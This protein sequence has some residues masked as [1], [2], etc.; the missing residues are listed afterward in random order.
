MTP[1]LK[2]WNWLKQYIQQELIPF[3]ANLKV[4]I[5]L[6]ILIA[7][8][9]STGTVIEQ[10]Q[11]LPFYQANYPESPALFGFITWKFI[12]GFGF[13]HVYHTWWFLGLLVWFGASLAA[14]TFSRQFPALKAARSWK[15][16]TQPRQFQK[17]AWSVEL[18]R[19]S[20]GSLRGYLNQRGYRIFEQD[21]GLYARKGIVGRIGPIVVH[22]SMLIILAGAMWGT[23][24]GFMAQEMVPSGQTFHIE[25]VVDAGPWSKGK[26]PQDWGVKVNRFWIEYTPQGQID[27]F[28][29]DLSVV[30]NDGDELDRQTI[31][32]NQPLRHDG[33]TFYQADWGIAAV[34]V[35]VNN[36]P[37]FEL[38][39]ASLQGT[40]GSKLWGTWV[41]TKPDMSEGITLITKDLQGT[42]VLYGMD[43]SPLG[44]VRT[45]MGV[46]VN[47]VTL[48]VLDL[49]GS[50]GL[51]IKLDP[52]IPIV[53]T[54]FALLMISVLM[55][56]VSHS[57]VWALEMDDRFYLGGRTNRAQVTFERELFAILEQLNTE[58]LKGPDNGLDKT[59]NIQDSEATA[60]EEPSTVA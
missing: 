11:S 52:G 44:T 43:G 19:G 4:A 8:F 25:N 42:L 41:P 59:S 60:T 21:N 47:G 40:T 28:Y 16:Y 23:Q 55:S 10:G 34:R 3:L 27:Q 17:L 45:G 22:A 31:F 30:D 48:S 54:G 35:R 36:S 2:P 49:V 18:D 14:C 39:M 1:I 37:I 5:V 15:F 29:S 38:P 24:T 12:L 26:V 20:L 51:Q 7:V 53:Y 50:T 33:I 46:E 58:A 6:L 57:Q 13:D 9:S 56:Y 32:V